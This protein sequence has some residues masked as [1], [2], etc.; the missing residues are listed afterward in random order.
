MS[1]PWSFAQVS[2]NSSG[3]ALMCTVLINAGDK[4]V[5]VTMPAEKPPALKLVCLAEGF[6]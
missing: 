4:C 1:L 2:D 6:C 5:I 3:M